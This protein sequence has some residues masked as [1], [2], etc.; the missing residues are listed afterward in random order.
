MNWDA[1]GAVAE[2]AGAVGV[3]VTLLFVA[4]QVRH[5]AKATD[6]NSI[7]LKATRLRYAAD[8]VSRFSELIA[9]NKEVASIW[10]RGVAGE[11]LD[12]DEATQFSWLFRNFVQ[13]HVTGYYDSGDDD[14][15]KRD[16][17]VEIVAGMVSRND[18]LQKPWAE[19]ARRFRNAARGEFVD[20]VDIRIG[21]QGNR[22]QN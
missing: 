22:D 14:P 15:V 13:I 5:S 10:R 1:V 20:A 21:S 11:E 7:E 12:E 6:N 16:S 17:N 18:G 2:L 19:A 3:I 9:G 4:L 8:A